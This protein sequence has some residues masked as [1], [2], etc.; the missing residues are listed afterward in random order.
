MRLNI[1]HIIL[2][3][4]GDGPRR[5]L[6]L[7]KRYNRKKNE[8]RRVS[9]GGSRLID[10]ESCVQGLDAYT[11]LSWID[12]H[13]TTRNRKSAAGN[14]TISMNE[15]DENYAIINH[16]HDHDEIN[17]NSNHEI[18]DKAVAH[19]SI[20]PPISVAVYQEASPQPQH[21]YSQQGTTTLSIAPPTVI[22]NE[23]LNNHPLVN[24]T[25]R[26]LTNATNTNQCILTTWSNKKNNVETFAWKNVNPDELELTRA[27]SSNS[28]RKHH[29]DEQPT[30]A[31]NHNNTVTVTK[32]D[33][34]AIFGE[35]IA[36]ELR[37][38]TGR[39]RAIVRHRIQTLLFEEKIKSFDENGEKDSAD[40]SPPNKIQRN[41]ISPS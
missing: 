13:I 31:S 16:H 36:E 11:F 29:I 22:S 32:K 21:Q 41:G 35:M 8:L 38:F 27:P 10:V 30:I 25:H 18:D 2:S 12:E 37:Q 23:K 4:I 20:S 19:Q 24:T 33:S 15:E 6:V 26:P 7:K 9:A 39:K 1:F 34:E 5:W 40:S 14:I 17:E 3:H 28:S